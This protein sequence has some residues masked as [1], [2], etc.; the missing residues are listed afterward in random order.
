MDDFI[1]SLTLAFGD[2]TERC[3]GRNA[4]ISAVFLKDCSEDSI[5]YGHEEKQ[6]DQIR[7]L[8]ES[9]KKEKVYT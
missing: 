9:T 5:K 3:K 6:K 2:T 4:V 1:V 8:W 7:R